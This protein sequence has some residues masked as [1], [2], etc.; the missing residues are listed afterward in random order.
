MNNNRIDLHTY[1]HKGANIIYY[2]SVI[3][4]ILGYILDVIAFEKLSERLVIINIAT[5]LVVLVVFLLYR[6]KRISLKISYGIIIYATIVNIFIDTFTD[7]FLPSRINF[8]MRD[9]L[10]IIIVLS[11]ASLIINKIHSI[12]IAAV[13][14]TGLSIFAAITENSFLLDSIY[15]IILII[16]AY[17]VVVYYFVTVIEKSIS[18]VEED[19]R[20]IK[21]QSEIVNKSYAL[22]LDHQ[23][24][25]EKQSVELIQQSELLQSQNK[26]LNKLVATKDK[27]FSIVAHDLKSPFNTI[28][29][30]IELLDIK[31][32]NID[33]DKKRSYIAHI[34]NAT[35]KTYN[36]LENLLLWAR[37]QSGRLES[38]PQNTSILK[39]VDACLSS[40]QQTCTEKQLKIVNNIDENCMVHADAGLVEIILRN[41]L[42]N[43]VKYTPSGGSLSIDYVFSD[44]I[45]EINI[46]DSGIGIQEVNISNLFRIDRTYKTAS[47]EGES[48]TGLG[49]IICNEL[50]RIQ[51]GTLKAISKAGEGSIFSF[52]LPKAV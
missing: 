42:S 36:L 40:F 50:I 16:S 45:I 21:E 11:L 18:S 12:I 44:P 29:G 46:A 28:L 19:S 2:I 6:L 34:K 32:D 27:F 43:A 25:I 39:L 14:L 7:P 9:T 35:A 8:L 20:T 52:T 26:E 41:L 30:F 31:F 33:D 4:V 17:A 15:L 48:G 3:I 13:Y 49:L 37:I 10:F 38:D 23:Q 22:L 47:I 5:V 1:L 24:K 51:G